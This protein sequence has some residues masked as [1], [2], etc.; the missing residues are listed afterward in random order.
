MNS[1][2]IDGRRL[3]IVRFRDRLYRANRSTFTVGSKASNDYR[4]APIKYFTLNEDELKA[5]TK[6]G[7]PYKKT[8]EPESDLVLQVDLVVVVGLLGYMGSYKHP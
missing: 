8:W 6:Y 1:I 2:T 4:G 3:K 7:M 5:Y